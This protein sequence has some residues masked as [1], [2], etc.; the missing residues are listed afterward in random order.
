MGAA[1]FGYGDGDET[2]VVGFGGTATA[3]AITTY[4]RTTFDVA[5]PAAVTALAMRLIRDDGVVVYLNGV[6]VFR[7][8]L[9]TGP[10]AY[11][12]DATTSVFGAGETTWLSANLNLAALRAGSNVL[13]VEIHQDRP[14]SSDISFDMELKG[15][16]A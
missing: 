10:I 4:F 3:K 12:T 14:D 16:T 15:T 7:N 13:A 1:Q 11:N 2:T 6:E 8:N 9:P 5:D